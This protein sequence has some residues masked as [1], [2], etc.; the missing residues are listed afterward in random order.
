MPLTITIRC[1][2]CA[3]S[4]TDTFRSWAPG[5]AAAH[6]D[7]AWRTAGGRSDTHTGPQR[8]LCALCASDEDGRR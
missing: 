3:M 6:L 5:E 2:N 1:D 8:W 4:L 7:E